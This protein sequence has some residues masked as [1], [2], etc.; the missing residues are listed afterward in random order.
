LAGPAVDPNRVLAADI[1]RHF[2]FMVVQL[3]DGKISSPI[4]K[5][6]KELENGAEDSLH[7]L[8]SAT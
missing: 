7:Y 2:P 4:T 8:Y 1:A 3:P 5:A 6:F